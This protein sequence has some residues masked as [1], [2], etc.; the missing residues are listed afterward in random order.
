MLEVDGKIVSLDLL[1]EGFCCDL[2]ACRG[3]CC[4]EGNAGAPLEPGEAEILEKLYPEYRPYMTPEGIEA[5]E[6]QGF[7][8]L[9]EDGDLTTTLVGGAE[10]AYSMRENGVT[11]CA[12]ERA[13]AA[14]GASQE[15]KAFPKPISCHLYPIRVTR[16]RDG[17]QG[18]NY[19]RWSI[20]APA[21]KSKIPVYRALRAPI[22]RAFGEDFFEALQQAEE[23]LESGE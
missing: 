16:F 22:I 9:D 15:L 8:V 21:R 1:R 20:C 12:I 4:V 19:H 13:A 2:A 23:Y 18:L 14:E 10:C 3:E 7:A 5:I 11:L 17:S 6:N